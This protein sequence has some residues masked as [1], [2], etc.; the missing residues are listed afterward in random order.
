MPAHPWNWWAIASQQTKTM[1]IR[2][3]HAGFGACREH[4]TNIN[5]IVDGQKHSMH[6]TPKYRSRTPHCHRLPPGLLHAL[7]AS[8]SRSF[9]DL[10]DR[11]ISQV[12]FIENTHVQNFCDSTHKDYYEYSNS[13]CEVR[14]VSVKSLELRRSPTHR[15]LD[16]VVRKMVGSLCAR[17]IGPIVW[18]VEDSNPLSHSRVRY[19]GVLI[20]NLLP[21]HICAQNICVSTHTKKR[22][23]YPKCMCL[24]VIFLYKHCN[25]TQ[26]PTR[27]F[28]IMYT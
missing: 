19:L 9:A 11:L 28:Y 13:Q 5:W 7:G 21:T 15:M 3:P 24:D 20:S 22:W 16:G 14:S 4:A 27:F 25:Q 2:R 26:S 8:A 10:S 12:K 17:R 1:T 23:K 6:S 18:K